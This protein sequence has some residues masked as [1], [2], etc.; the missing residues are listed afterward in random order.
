MSWAATAWARRRFAREKGTI[1]K[2]WGGRLPIA[3]VYPNAYRVGMSSL[4]FQLIYRLLNSE[5][6]VVCERC[7][8]EPSLLR[9]SEP[10]VTMEGQR[11]LADFAAIAFS[12]TFELDYFQVVALLRQAGLPTRAA[13]RDEG[14][15]LVLGGGP[16]LT[17]NPEPLA[18]LFDAVAVGEAET[19]LPGILAAVREKV[20]APRADLLRRLAQAPG[21]YVPSLHRVGDGSGQHTRPRPV[22]R[23]WVSDLDAHPGYSSLLTDETEFGRMFLLEVARGC[24]RGCRFCL[25]GYCFRPMRER[26]LGVLL[27]QARLGL[28]S[29]DRV[30]LMGPAVS[31]YS[32]IDEL[33]SRLREMGARVSVASLRLDRL[34]DRLLQALVESGTKSIA[35]AP[36]AGSERLRGFLSKTISDDEILAAAA[37]IARRGVRKVKLYYMLGLPSETEAESDEVIRLTQEIGQVLSRR[38]TGAELTATISPFVP[39]AQTPFQWEPMLERE[40]LSQRLRRV[41]LGLRALGVAAKGESPDWSEVQGVLARGDRRLFGVLDRL[42]SFA[43]ADALARGKTPELRAWREA[44]ESEGLDADEY[45]RPR[46]APDEAPAWQ[47]VSS[48]VEPGFL[49]QE[50]KRAGGGR[51]AIAC[52]GADCSA[53]GVCLPVQGQRDGLLL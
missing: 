39:K 50:R 18:P 40:A 26:S 12:V 6:G 19:I 43:Q 34:S 37:Q 2:D 20:E 38:K 7:F 47:A 28:E 17:A 31:D 49:W 4:G 44:M 8:W 16:C 22:M 23:R 21:V 15:P 13:D 42:G 9:G 35:L 46:R 25:A 3:L 10:P 24:G 29:T 27:D 32:A 14:H 11:P 5:V 48:G 45:L 36:E 1:T 51:P 30:G 53:C 33:A 52:P 41:R